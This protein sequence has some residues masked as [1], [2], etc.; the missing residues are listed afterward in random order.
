MIDKLLGMRV[1][2]CGLHP[3]PLDEFTVFASLC[4]VDLALD[5]VIVLVVGGFGQSKHELIDI[6]DEEDR[7]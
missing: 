3:L 6:V 7:A 4:D 1:S 2:E 5:D